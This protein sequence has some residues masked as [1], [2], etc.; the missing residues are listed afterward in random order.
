MLL[1][2]HAAAPASHIGLVILFDIKRDLSAHLF[3]LMSGVNNDKVLAV[4]ERLLARYN[5][6]NQ[7][8]HLHLSLSLLDLIIC[9]SV[10]PAVIV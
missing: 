1:I 6:K 4:Q 2:M 3:F 7:I 10:S 5:W 9:K 8:K